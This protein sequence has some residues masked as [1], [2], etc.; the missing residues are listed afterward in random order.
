MKAEWPGFRGPR[1]D[2]VIRGV[3]IETDWAKSPPVELLRRQIG[4]AWSSFAVSGDLLFTQ[5]QRGDDEVVAA[6]NVKT[7]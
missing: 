2:R 3:R 7:G 1:G 5:E 6:Y 4:P